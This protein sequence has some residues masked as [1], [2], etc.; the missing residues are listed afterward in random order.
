MTTE[1]LLKSLKEIGG[2]L[3]NSKN[4]LNRPDEDVVTFSVCRNTHDSMKQLMLLYL[5]NH[6]V[7]C[8]DTMN[9]D[10]L[11][12]LCHKQNPTFNQVDI[13]SIDCRDQGYEHGNG[14]YCL[15]VDNV[16]CCTNV[17][18]QMKAVIWNELKID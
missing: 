14:K 4:E 13:A 5:M 12:S 9:L 15:S 6:G 7:S 2:K 16:N 3:D 8:N 17:A 10:E 1:E 11:Y 18:H